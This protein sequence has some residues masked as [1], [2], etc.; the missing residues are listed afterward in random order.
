MYASLFC[1]S[2][3][4]G[5]KPAFLGQKGTYCCDQNCRADPVMQNMSPEDMCTDMVQTGLEFLPV[6]PS[7]LC[8]FILG[9]LLG[10]HNLILLLHLKRGEKKKTCKNSDLALK[11]CD[12]LHCIHF[13]MTGSG[14]LSLH[15]SLK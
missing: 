8:P 3:L 7:T 11:R 14:S 9:Y 5:S 10:I 4:I 1:K 6:C 13:K 12:I 2:P 15:D